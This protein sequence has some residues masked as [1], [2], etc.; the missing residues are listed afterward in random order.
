MKRPTTL[1]SGAAA[2]MLLA[3]AACG[4]HHPGAAAKAKASASALA[5]NPTIVHDKKLAEQD[6]Q[7]C[8]TQTSILLHPHKGKAAFEACV[9][10]KAATPA[11]FNA[12]VGHLNLTAGMTALEVKLVNCMVTK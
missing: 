5:S 10:S 12:C 8:A 3:L 6:L 2:L 11:K 1:A 7:T 9:K 4:T